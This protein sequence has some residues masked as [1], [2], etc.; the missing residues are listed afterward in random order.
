MVDV[1]FQQGNGWED[2]VFCDVLLRCVMLSSLILH[3]AASFRGC[4][5]AEKLA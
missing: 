4:A 5:A 1:R 3:S 2:T